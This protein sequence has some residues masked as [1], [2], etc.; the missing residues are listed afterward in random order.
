MASAQTTSCVQH[1]A[2][3]RNTTVH[4]FVIDDGTIDDAAVLQLNHS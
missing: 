2:R 3:F 4:G 1:C